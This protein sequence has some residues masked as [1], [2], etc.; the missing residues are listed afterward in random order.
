MADAVDCRLPVPAFTYH[1]TNTVRGRY[2]VTV[3]STPMKNIEPST[4]LIEKSKWPREDTEET[5]NALNG[6]LPSLDLVAPICI[7]GNGQMN[8]PRVRC[9]WHPANTSLAAPERLE[10]HLPGLGS[11][12]LQAL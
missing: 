2:L 9:C 6:S 3:T 10:P 12:L 5:G 11:A 7:Y 4:S 8:I 1:L